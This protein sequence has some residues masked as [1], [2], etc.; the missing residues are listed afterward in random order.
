MNKVLVALILLFGFVNQALASQWAWYGAVRTHAAHYK[1]DEKFLGGPNI[2]KTIGA[3]GFK[4]AGNF[5]NLAGNSVLGARSHVTE[6]LYGHVELGLTNAAL[7]EGN[8]QYDA[9]SIYL[10]SMFGKYRIGSASFLFGKHYTPSTFLLYSTMTADLGDMG[11]ACLLTTAIPYTGRRAQ[12]KLNVA[13]FE[14]ALVEHAF[15]NERKMTPIED[16]D[17]A[18][19]SF[20]KIELAYQWNSP[21]VSLR[22]IAGYQTYIVEN[23]L[24]VETQ[25]I[26]SLLYGLGVNLHLGNSRIN[27]TAAMCT[28]PDQYGIKNVTTPYAGIGSVRLV[29]GNLEEAR[30][31]QSSFVINYK[32]SERVKFE[33]GYGYIKAEQKMAANTDWELE[34]TIWYANLPI[35]FG[36]NME[37]TPEIGTLDRGRVKENGSHIEAGE[38]GC[39]EWVSIR[40]AISF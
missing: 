20:P 27:L 39:M 17:D 15:I 28:N 36:P 18:D 26:T 6:H 7:V 37:L 3:Y 31:L 25:T 19:F 30:L 33:G 1:I 38:L 12:I 29:D 22:P 16:Y 4:D 9:E 5:I 23:N 21:V 32:L 10:R 24:T 2:D 13:G 8:D 11:D 14:A 34:S 40:L 35:Y